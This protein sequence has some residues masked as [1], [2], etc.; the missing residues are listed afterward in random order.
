MKRS[1]L[2]DVLTSHHRKGVMIG[3]AANR[4][5]VESAERPTYASKLQAHRMGV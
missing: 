5:G 1:T 3:F 4:A 2:R